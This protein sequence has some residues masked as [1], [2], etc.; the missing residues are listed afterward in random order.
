MAVHSSEKQKSPPG[1][2]DGLFFRQSE[3]GQGLLTCALSPIFVECFLPL[4]Q[5]F[6]TFA[7]FFRPIFIGLFFPLS[8]IFQALAVTFGPILAIIPITHP[9]GSVGH[10]GAY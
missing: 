9:S 10:G 7:T 4:P 8:L 6:E 5:V 1:R 2:S 3:D